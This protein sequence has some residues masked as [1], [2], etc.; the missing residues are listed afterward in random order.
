[1]IFRAGEQ[2]AMARI[3]ADKSMILVDR[4]II[5]W[6][7]L[8]IGFY[9]GGAISKPGDGVYPRPQTDAITAAGG[10]KARL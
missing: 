5:I 2:E 1:M 6:L 3:A 9:S 10:D 4:R 7:F 8:I